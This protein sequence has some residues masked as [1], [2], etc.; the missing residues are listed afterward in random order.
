MRIV[1][2]R[3]AAIAGRAGLVTLVMT[4][5]AA[6]HLSHRCFSRSGH[7]SGQRRARHRKADHSGDECGEESS[8]E[9][10]IDFEPQGATCQTSVN[11]SKS[12]VRSH[13]G[14]DQSPHRYAFAAAR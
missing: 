11:Y 8:A 2:L 7:T 6:G 5:L 9:H 12:A 14:G 3:L 4:V 13:K 1:M 10:E